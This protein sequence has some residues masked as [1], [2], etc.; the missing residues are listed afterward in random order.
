MLGCRRPGVTEQLHVLEGERIIKATRGHVTLLDRAR[1]EERAGG[2]YG[3]PEREYAR[4]MCVEDKD[5]E[6]THANGVAAFQPRQV[7][8]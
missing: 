5:G 1:L 3:V 2:C 4:V 7:E 6:P 8:M